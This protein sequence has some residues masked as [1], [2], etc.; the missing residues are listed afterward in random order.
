VSV[1]LT[2]LAAMGLLM[3]GVSREVNDLWNRIGEVARGNRNGTPPDRTTNFF[4]AKRRI[5]PGGGE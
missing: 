1:I 4:R 3:V 2:E 5:L